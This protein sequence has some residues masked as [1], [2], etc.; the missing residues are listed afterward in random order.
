MF[1]AHCGSLREVTFCHV[2]EVNGHLRV[3]LTWDPKRR[4]GHFPVPL[5]AQCG[6]KDFVARQYVRGPVQGD[7]HAG[8]RGSSVEQPRPSREAAADVVGIEAG[9]VR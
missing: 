6:A 5:C 1:C 4:D 2:R 8:A 7:E 3:S 9:A